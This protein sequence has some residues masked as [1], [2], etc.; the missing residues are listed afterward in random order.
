[1]K[2]IDATALKKGFRGAFARLDR[3]KEEINALNVFPV[4]DGDTGTNMSLTM[5]SAIQAIEE[6]PDTIEGVM[7]ALGS[8]SLMGA[9]GNSGVILSQLCRGFQQATKGKTLL[10]AGDLGLMFEAARAKAYKAVMQPTEGTILT[11]ARAMS[12][13][14]SANPN[15]ED[16]IAFLKGVLEH[17]NRTLQQTPEML[18]E[19]KDAGV[20]DAGGQGLV[21]LLAGFIEG[22]SGEDVSDLLDRSKV[23]TSVPERME[24]GR[25]AAEKNQMAYYVEFTIRDV[26]RKRMQRHLEKYGVMQGVQPAADGLHVEAYTDEPLK[27]LESQAR[28]GDLIDVHF[29]KARAHLQAEVVAEDANAVVAP[30]EVTKDAGFVAVCT[31]EGFAQLFK[32][33]MVDEVVVGG[34]TMNPSTR[35]LF[36]ATERVPAKSVFILPNNK[37]IIMAAE[38]VQELSSKA[39][40]VIASRSMPEGITALFQF[41]ATASDAQNV[42]AMEESLQTVITGS[43]TYAV[44]D[45]EMNG[46]HIQ[47]G[48][49]IGMVNGKIVACGKTPEALVEQL[50]GETIESEH[51]LLTV[52]TG[53][54]ATQDGVESLQ[55]AIAMCWPELECEVAEGGQP[56]YPYIFSIE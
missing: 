28:R 17:A 42:Q 10:V 36:E 43:V 56:L 25:A 37:N 35:D 24:A 33:L 52:Y 34:Q 49:P 15:E 11:I 26:E 6:A 12:E 27:L 8:G 45:S 32:D 29:A 7:K 48:A 1:M 38:Q 18:K 3:H 31:G 53:E 23:T 39:I 22:L 21:Y 4:P 40:Y 47:A 5:K 41:D 55:K 54:G 46:L 13:Y 51:T 19:L 30:Q 2:H 9:R 20:V 14:A 50:I 16:V 44:R